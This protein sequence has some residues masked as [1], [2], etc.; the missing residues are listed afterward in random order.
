MPLAPEDRSALIDGAERVTALA[1]I[2]KTLALRFE[3]PIRDVVDACTR[4]HDVA[5]T[6]ANHAQRVS[7]TAGQ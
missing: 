1:S 2:V 5:Q 3:P 6:L 4:L 7:D